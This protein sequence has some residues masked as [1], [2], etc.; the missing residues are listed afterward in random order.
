VVIDVGAQIGVFSVYVA[1]RGPHR[2]TVHSFEPMSANFDLLRR[3]LELNLLTQVTPH[4]AAVTAREGRFRLF[5]S[6]DNT[7]AHSLFG[8][9]SEFE[10]VEGRSFNNLYDSLN[11]AQ[12]D[13][14][15]LD[16]E[17][18]EY[19][20]LL[21]ATD[22]VLNRTGA[23]IMEY[24]DEAKLPEMMARLRQAGFTVELPRNGAPMLHAW[25]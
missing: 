23:I 15:K 24:H 10:E 20:I 9:G 18:A 11:V 14:L 21:T 8:S 13:V 16:C 4:R 5:V 2:L 19:E 25:R 7:G 3:N 6:P 22:D 1:R 12:C 17:G